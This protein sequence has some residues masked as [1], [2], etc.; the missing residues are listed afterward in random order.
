MSSFNEQPW[1]YIV[2]QKKNRDTYADV[3]DCLTPGNQEWVQLAP[4]LGI[5]F[6]KKTFTKNDKPNRVHAYDAGAATAYLTLQA[7]EEGLQVHQMAGIDLEKVRKTFQIPDKL[8]VHAGFAIGNEGSP[9][10]LPE[11]LQKSEKATRH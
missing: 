10:Q 9:E 5:S 2:G 8:G 1:R 4:V 3:L 6:S 7:V 11:H